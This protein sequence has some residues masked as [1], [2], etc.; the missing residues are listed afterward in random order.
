MKSLRSCFVDWLRKH[1]RLFSVAKKVKAFFVREKLDVSTVS[2]HAFLAEKLA[3]RLPHDIDCVIG[4]GRKGLLVADIIALRLGLPLSTPEDFLRGTIWQSKSLPMHPIRKVLVVD[5]AISQ[6][7]ELKASVESIK[8]HRPDL[9]VESL[10]IS[11]DKPEAKQIVD[12]YAVDKNKHF[13][14]YEW[15]MLRRNWGR[16]CLD[17]DGVLCQDDS[18]EP[19]LIPRY[20]IEAIISNRPESERSILEHWLATNRVSYGKLILK[21]S[22]SLPSWKHKAYWLNRLRPKWYWESSLTEARRIARR[23]N[24]PILC[25]EDMQVHRR[26]LFF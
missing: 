16:L 17:F 26:I 13:G 12:Y 10:V 4:I 1:P 9:I 18:M 21:Q 8:A 7:R 23:T 6:G 25:I 24:V 11:V 15:D 22:P 5:D 14:I 2:I 19:Y 20:H 3:D